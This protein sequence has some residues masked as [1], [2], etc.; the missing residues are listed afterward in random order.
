[1]TANLFE[2]G[3]AHARSSDPQTSHDAARSVTGSTLKPSQVDTLAA[4]RKRGP[5]TQAGIETLLAGQYSP[6]RIRTAVSE[7]RDANLVRDTG[8]KERLPSGRMAIVWEAYP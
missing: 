2:W 3:A 1:M 4:L 8:R 5:S 7:L 6:S